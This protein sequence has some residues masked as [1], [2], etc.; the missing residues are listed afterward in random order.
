MNSRVNQGLKEFRWLFRRDA[1]PRTAGAITKSGGGYTIADT[2]TTAQ[3]G[4]VY[5]A[6]TATTS[7]MVNKEYKVIAASTNS[8]TIASKDLPTLGDTF[9]IMG[10]VTP[11]VDDKGAI[12]VSSTQAPIQFVYNGSDIE[13]ALD[14]TTAANSRPLP[15]WYVN[16][17][18]TKTDLA[19]LAEQQT[20]TTSLG[21]INT[22]VNTLL[23]PAS[24]L[25]GITT[26]G[27]VTT[28]STVSSVTAI[29][30]A[31]PAGSNEIGAVNNA[32]VSGT[33]I[34]VGSGTLDAGTQRV[35]LATDQPSL[36]VT[37]TNVYSDSTSSGSITTQNLVP[38]GNATA[39]S[40]V[41]T[42]ANGTNSRGSAIVTVTGTYTGALSLQT[43]ADGSVWRTSSA[44]SAI[45]NIGAGTF[46]GTIASGTQ[47][48]FQI[49]TAGQAYVRI[50]ALAAVTGTA[51]VAIRTSVPGGG[52]IIQGPLPTGTNVIGALSANQSTNIAQ[53]N[54]VATSMGA[55]ADSTGTQRVTISNNATAT[56]A[57]VTAS[58][59]SVAVL[60]SA[61]T[62]RHATFYND[63]AAIL[64]LK[65]GATASTTSYTVQ[66]QANGYYELPQ[67]CYSG[68]I[69]GIWSS[70]TGTVRVTSW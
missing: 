32:K 62:R 52:T 37:N 1:T 17:A 61:A 55:G 29:A 36:S 68:A 65:F 27:T 19:T 69:D 70:A 15:I 46:S 14:T 10:Y 6:E 13:V 22:S 49:M 40:A 59:T 4:D 34:S 43:S 23:K 63:S 12:S 64:Y 25:A 45:Y 20:Q 30:N 44:D 11:K 53:M 47:G 39:N 26:V 54:G 67:P 24:T 9:Y 38:L 8:F 42:I 57:N 31:L 28:V 18:G 2:S 50:T 48:D 41:A 21:T 66:I 33:A 3:V 58:A 35:V 56:L 60:A 51:T 16:G 5:R 7:K